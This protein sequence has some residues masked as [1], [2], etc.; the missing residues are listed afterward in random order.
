M[1]NSLLEQWLACWYQI[2][3][4]AYALD[5]HWPVALSA[6]LLALVSHDS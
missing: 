3:S 5:V 4:F 2:H 6:E 1:Q